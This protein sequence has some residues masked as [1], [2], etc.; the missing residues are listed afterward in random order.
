MDI[1]NEVLLL[2]INPQSTCLETKQGVLMFSSN[3]LIEILNFVYTSTVCFLLEVAWGLIEKLVKFPLWATETRR[4]S[5]WGLEG[6]EP[7]LSACRK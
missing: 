6:N 2:I 5:G 1:S 4:R 7:K 3:S